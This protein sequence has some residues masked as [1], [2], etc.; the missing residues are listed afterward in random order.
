MN[1]L[2]H[3]FRSHHS[4]PKIS[5]NVLFQ[6]CLCMLVVLFTSWTLCGCYGQRDVD[7]LLY[8]N[9]ETINVTV[10]LNFPFFTTIFSASVIDTGSS[11]RR[12]GWNPITP[13]LLGLFLVVI[14]QV[15]ILKYWVLFT[16]CIKKEL[17][18]SSPPTHLTNFSL[19]IC[20]IFQ[21]PNTFKHYINNFQLSRTSGILM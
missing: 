8:G 18:I 3:D 15:K 13:R 6:Q 7:K 19:Q 17:N 2:R 1:L 21:L 12:P 11:S 5:Y 10:K 16:V 20:N 14:C 9:T 4:L